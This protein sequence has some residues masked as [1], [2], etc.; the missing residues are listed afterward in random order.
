MPLVILVVFLAAFTITALVVA[1][2]QGQSVSPQRLRTTLASALKLSRL[3]KQ[4]EIVD[5]RKD[6]SLSALPWLHELLTKIDAAVQLRR[7]LGQADL[8]WTPAR[9]LLSATLA[10]VLAA[11]AINFWWHA[12]LISLLLGMPAAAVPFLIVL[13]KRASRFYAFETALPNALDLM[14]SALRAG[15]S[16]V[17]AL[18]IVATDAPQP[19]RGE[20]SLC[21]E[22]QNYGMDLRLAFDNMLVR[23]PLPDLRII[24]AAILIQ[25][26]S[27][28]NLAEVL[29]KTAYVIR[30]RFYLRDQ[31]RLRTV[32][33]RATGWILTI[34][35]VALGI[36]LSVLNPRYMSTLITHPMGRK[37]MLVGCGMNLFGLF[38]IRK[39]IRIRI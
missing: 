5:V 10:W 17:G 23:L 36:L 29:E 13:K 30:A 4:E 24:L 25:K 12:G 22:E 19:V 1:A 20:F 8:N 2:V 16:M 21:F 28:G 38:V 7:M 6:R 27:G 33:S 18:K 35:P 11:A 15:H 39:I 34:M 31:I 14:V 32:Q 26:E 37:L 9:L 3:S